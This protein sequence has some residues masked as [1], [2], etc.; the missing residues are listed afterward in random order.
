MKGQTNGPLRVGPLGAGFYSG[1]MATVPAEWQAKLGGPALTGQAD[2][3]VISRTSYGP[4]VFAFDP[5]NMNASGAKPLVYYPSDHP[6]LG[7]WDGANSLYSGADSVKGVVMPTGSSSVLFVGRHG[8]TFCYGP[9]TSDASLAGKP[10]G[11]GVDPWCYDPESTVKGTHGYPYAP[12]VWAYDANQLASVRAGQLQP[13]E[14]KPYAVWKLPGLS[15]Y[16]IGGA[17]YDPATQRVYV[18]ELFADG[19]QLLIHVFTVNP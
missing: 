19:D 7:P 1:Y 17:A 5:A 10:S 16:E 9:G 14:V 18:S 13:W 4:G 6:T 12:Q 2:L 3:S 11:N 15:G 8:S